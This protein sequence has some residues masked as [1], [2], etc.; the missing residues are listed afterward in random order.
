[1]QF[2]L[3]PLSPSL[4]AAGDEFLE[5]YCNDMM[6]VLPGTDKLGR[7][8]ISLHPSNMT[9]IRVDPLLIRCVA[10]VGTAV[11]CSTVS[12]EPAV[13][14]LQHYKSRHRL[15]FLRTRCSSTVANR[16]RLVV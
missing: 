11:E 1:M 2:F 7:R 6:R 3:R 16:L 14:V 15:C 5:L 9:E 13:L 12:R 8:I 10:M 4:T